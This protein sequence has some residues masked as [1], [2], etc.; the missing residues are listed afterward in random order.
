MLLGTLLFRFGAG[1]L[2]LVLGVERGKVR[3]VGSLQGGDV[4]LFLCDLSLVL[5]PGP[6]QPENEDDDG[7]SANANCNPLP[8]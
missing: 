4:D 5:S 7:Y 8:E 3:L 2:L 1:D 6:E